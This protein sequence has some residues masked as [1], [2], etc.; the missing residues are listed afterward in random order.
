MSHEYL[1]LEDSKSEELCAQYLMIPALFSEALW[2][3]FVRKIELAVQQR[4]I[5]LLYSI[6]RHGRSRGEAL[7][8]HTWLLVLTRRYTLEGLLALKG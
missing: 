7:V 8:K 1:P 5:P 6:R 2:A 4:C 3:S